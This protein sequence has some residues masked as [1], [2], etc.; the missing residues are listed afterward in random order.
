MDPTH[1]HTHP[2]THTS[3]QLQPTQQCPVQ[4]SQ[5]HCPHTDAPKRALRHWP[6]S[7]EQHTYL[8]EA[9]WGPLKTSNIRPPTAWLC[10]PAPR[11][12]CCASPTTHASPCHFSHNGYPVHPMRTPCPCRAAPRRAL[13]RDRHFQPHYTQI[14]QQLKPSP[15][16]QPIRIAL[17]PPPPPTPHHPHAPTRT[18][19]S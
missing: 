1:T 16:T 17:H 7:P 13:R 14:S 19:Y 18:L 15:T 3:S 5:P 4:P 11:G 10:A 2:H 8:T 9:P 6:H 12:R